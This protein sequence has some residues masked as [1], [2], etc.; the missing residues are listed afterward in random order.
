[1]DE[2]LSVEG[3][4][5]VIFTGLPVSG[6]DIKH[7]RDN[8]KNKFELPPEQLKLIFKGGPVALQK[9]LDWSTATKYSAAMKEMG[10]LCEI[11]RGQELIEDEVGLAPCPQCKSLQIGEVCSDCGFDI[12]SYRVQMEEKGFIEVADSGYIRNRRDAPRRL[13]KDRRDDVRYEEKRRSGLD[14]RKKNTDW[15]SD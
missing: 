1:M 15:Y 14:R 8:F 12:K 5:Q 10:A 7:V 11:T 2:E 6:T 4:Y 3:E 9:K 13:N